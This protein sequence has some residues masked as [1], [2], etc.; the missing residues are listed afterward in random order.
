MQQKY[1]PFEQMKRTAKFHPNN[2]LSNFLI[3]DTMWITGCCI[4]Y[5]NFELILHVHLIFMLETFVSDECVVSANDVMLRKIQLCVG[6]QLDMFHKD[7]F[8]FAHSWKWI[9]NSIFYVLLLNKKYLS[10][11]L[12]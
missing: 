3:L 7:V 10:C 11:C 12:L 2:K 9:I 6:T 1:F 8:F 5:L 4:K